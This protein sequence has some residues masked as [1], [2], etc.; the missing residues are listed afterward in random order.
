MEHMPLTRS[1]PFTEI[2]P[3]AGMETLWPELAPPGARPV[4]VTA[5]V[6]N[7]D[8]RQAVMSLIVREDDAVRAF[9]MA[10]E[11]CAG[12]DGFEIRVGRHAG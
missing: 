8:S 2:P 9:A 7:G 11:H 5:T 12:V 4:S 3:G 10:L 1:Q 6:P